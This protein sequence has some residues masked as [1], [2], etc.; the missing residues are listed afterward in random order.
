MSER[1]YI[2]AFPTRVSFDHDYVD[3]LKK[4]D[5]DTERHF[6]EYFG[7]LLRI[8]LHARLRNAQMV[9]DLTQE[10]FLRV[11]TVVRRENGIHSP[12]PS[13]VREHGLQ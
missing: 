3:R 13:R 11:L 7:K 8:K 5:P 10:T 4:R 6:V 1:V 12:A 2:E 9:E